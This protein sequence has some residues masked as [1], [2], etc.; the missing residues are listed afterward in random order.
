MSVVTKRS[1]RRVLK[2]DANGPRF[3]IVRLWKV[4]T[5]IKAESIGKEETPAD[6]MRAAFAEPFRAM[7]VDRRGDIYADNHRD[8]Q[9]RG[10]HDRP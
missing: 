5:A 1:P 6:A 10:P 7:A 9:N 3:R 2:P 4:G 8:I